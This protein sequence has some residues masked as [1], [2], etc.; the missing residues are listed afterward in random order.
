MYFTRI[1]G[2]SLMQFCHNSPYLSPYATLT[3]P[4]RGVVWGPH[5]RW[6]LSIP[7][8]CFPS[9]KSFCVKRM[10]LPYVTT[11]STTGEMFSRLNIA[12][13][14]QSF[15][16]I[17]MPASSISILKYAVLK[18]KTAFLSSVR[19]GIASLLS[20]CSNSWQRGWSWDMLF[21]LLTFCELQSQCWIGENLMTTLKQRG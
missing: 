17:Y 16:W 15:P 9:R 7:N 14:P 10:V 12:L 20:T 1:W 19:T 4:G 6:L 5:G 18:P 11:T 8:C 3:L 2:D 13:A 21:S